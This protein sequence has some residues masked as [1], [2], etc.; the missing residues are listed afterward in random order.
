MT[1]LIKPSKLLIGIY[2][3]L[4]ASKVLVT[5]SLT[6]GWN[7]QVGR[8]GV[9]LKRGGSEI[10]L[11]DSTGDN[12]TR[13]LTCSEAN[14][15]QWCEPLVFTYLD[16]PGSAATHTYTA[17]LWH[18]YQGTFTAYLN[19]AGYETN[20]NYRSRATSSITLMEVSA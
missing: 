5:I 19:R 13:L 18:G 9:V 20:H 2:F 12:K 16:S 15:G 10:A 3:F 8:S 11:S 4:F 17:H 14:G 7:D 1:C 6:I